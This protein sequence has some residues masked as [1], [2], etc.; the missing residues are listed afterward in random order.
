MSATLGAL[1]VALF[2]WPSKAVVA[3][4]VAKAKIY[5]HAKPTAALREHHMG[6]QTGP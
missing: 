1:P 5:V 2:V 4:P 6:L 3:R